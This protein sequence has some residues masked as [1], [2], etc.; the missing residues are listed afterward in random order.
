MSDHH[1]ALERDMLRMLV[2]GAGTLAFPRFPEGEEEAEGW[3][4]LR[5]A[6]SH[7]D[8]VDSPHPQGGNRI[9]WGVAAP[10]GEDEREVF[11]TTTL[12]AADLTDD[13]ESDLYERLQRGGMCVCGHLR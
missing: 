5:H 13:R 12:T 3:Y 6:G 8:A 9:A 1:R 7:R 10:L 2:R 11:G 4:K